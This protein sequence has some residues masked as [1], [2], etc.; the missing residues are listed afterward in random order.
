MLGPGGWGTSN[1]TVRVWLLGEKRRF[2]LEKGFCLENTFKLR[3]TNVDHLVPLPDNVH[4][5]LASNRDYSVPLSEDAT[6]QLFNVR[7]GAVLRTFKHNGPLPLI[8]SLTLMPDGLRFVA[9]SSVLP[10]DRSRALILYHGL[11]PCV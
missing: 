2:G 7:N 8:G 1:N 11:A 9:V 10:L 3:N 4:A 5:L 6:L